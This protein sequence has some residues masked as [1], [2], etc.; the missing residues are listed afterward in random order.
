MHELAKISNDG[1]VSAT[2]VAFPLVPPGVGRDDTVRICHANPV[3]RIGVR[4]HGAHWPVMK[5]KPQQART[6]ITSG[7]R[8]AAG[9]ST[10]SAE[11][12][13]AQNGLQLHDNP[14]DRS[15]QTV[16]DKVT[17]ERFER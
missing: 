14:A 5:R 15:F 1:S 9:G 16:R 17:Q 8:M 4:L 11:P 10:V 6:A 12:S 2:V 7:L 13:G 3:K